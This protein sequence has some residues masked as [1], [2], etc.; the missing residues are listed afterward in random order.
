MRTKTLLFV[1]VTFVL[2]TI[3]SSK[4]LAQNDLYMPRD[5]KMAYDNGTRAYDGKP[6]KNYWQNYSNYK[7]NVKVT[8][9]SR[10]VEGEETI[11]YHNNS[12]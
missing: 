12:P 6:G 3:I 4:I 11:I 5:I 8:P 1:S 10:L 7:I 9:S 2:T